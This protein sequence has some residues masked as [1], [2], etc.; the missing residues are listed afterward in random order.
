MAPTR[1]SPQKPTQKLTKYMGNEQEKA[2][3]ASR[4]KFALIHMKCKPD[5]KTHWTLLVI[6]KDQYSH[7][8]FPN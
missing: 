8:V 1:I 6:I 2:G 4:V 5:L 3:K 7:L